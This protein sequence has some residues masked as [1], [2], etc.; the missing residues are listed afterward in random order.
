MLR[1]ARHDACLL[2]S[3]TVNVMLSLPKRDIIVNILFL[4]IS[5]KIGILLKT[6]FFA[7]SY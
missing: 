6:L 1:Q 7:G 3:Y 4:S 2:Q 5:L